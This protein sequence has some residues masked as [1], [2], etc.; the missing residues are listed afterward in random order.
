MTTIKV[1]KCGLDWQ[2]YCTEHDEAHWCSWWTDALEAAY[3]H[4]AMHHGHKWRTEWMHRLASGGGTICRTKAD[5]IATRDKHDAYQP[6]PC[7][8]R[9]SPT[10]GIYR[11]LVTAWESE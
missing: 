3:G 2:M 7:E 6:H 1:R 10:V 9:P 5:A 8:P 11:R 4:A